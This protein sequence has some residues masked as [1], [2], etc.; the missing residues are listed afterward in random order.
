MSLFFLREK[1][2]SKEFR[3]CV[4]NLMELK[5]NTRIAWNF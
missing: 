5:Y 3:Y 2:P 4:G 1:A